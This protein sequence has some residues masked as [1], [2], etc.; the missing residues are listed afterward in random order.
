MA[1]RFPVSSIAGDMISLR[2]AMD[3][4]FNEGFVQ[5]QGGGMQR[6]LPLDVYANEN[7]V[8]VLAAIPG[9]DGNDIQITIE[10]NVLTLSGSVPNVADSEDAKEASWYLHE[11]P[12]GSFERTLTLPME[13]DSNRAEAT[14]DNGMLRL[15]LPKAETAKPRQIKVKVG[16]AEQPEA[17]DVEA[18]A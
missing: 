5:G 2:H 11:L 10:K 16:G 8:V 3:R 13:L 9:M 6:A 1:T 7:E 17:V 18:G 12:Y 4:L 15:V 14:I